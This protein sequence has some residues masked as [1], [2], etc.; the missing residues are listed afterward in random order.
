LSSSIT[1]ISPNSFG[2]ASIAVSGGAITAVSITDL[3]A[4]Y[5]AP[6]LEISGGSGNGTGAIVTFALQSLQTFHTSAAIDAAV[7][8]VLRVAGGK[9]IVTAG[10]TG[11]TSF[12]CTMVSAMRRH[13]PNTAIGTLAPVLASSGEWSLTR[14]VTILGGL[15]H[16]EGQT[17]VG[18]ADGSLV[19]PTTVSDGCIALAQPASAIVLGLGYTSQL[20]TLRMDVENISGKRRIVPSVTIRTVDSR[21]FFVGPDFKRPG[22]MIEQKNRSTELYGQPI[23]FQSGGGIVAPIFAGMPTAPNPLGY[24]DT[25]MNVATSWNKD[26]YVC[27]Q[28]SYPLPVTIIDVVPNVVIG[29]EG[30]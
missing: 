19:P 4:N 2:G 26:G 1:S 23:E 30:G 8:D 13:V 15:D 17:V 22:A 5:T 10:T 7:G 11:G 29:D 20:Q 27:I 6:R 9:G 28:Q 24:E 16:L 21:G 3:G 14:P 18:L 25:F 12:T